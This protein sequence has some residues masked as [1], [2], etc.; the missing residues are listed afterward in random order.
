VATLEWNRWKVCARFG[1]KE[2]A[3]SVVSFIRLSIYTLTCCPSATYDG[4]LVISIV[5]LLATI[6]DE[7]GFYKTLGG[8]GLE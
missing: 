6:F 2:N 3:E 4:A 7:V 5:S 8:G 1:G